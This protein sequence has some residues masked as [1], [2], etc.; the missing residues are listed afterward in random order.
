MSLIV[1]DI[2]FTPHP[3]TRNQILATCT[4]G[5]SA[6]GPSPEIQGKAACHDLDIEPE[7]Y[8]EGAITDAYKNGYRTKP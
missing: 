5:W 4:C 6:F 8:I 1:H 2:S 7:L 3:S